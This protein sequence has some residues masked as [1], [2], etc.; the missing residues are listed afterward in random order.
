MSVGQESQE[1][2]D[3]IDALREALRMAPLYKSECGITDGE[4]FRQSP[5]T[6]AVDGRLGDGNRQVR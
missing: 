5:A 1:I 6:F 3:F 4:R 2:R